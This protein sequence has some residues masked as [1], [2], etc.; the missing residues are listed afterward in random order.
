MLRYFICFIGSAM[1]IVPKCS[2]LPWQNYYWNNWQNSATSVQHSFFLF[3][4]SHGYLTAV[5]RRRQFNP[6]WPQGLVSRV[7]ESTVSGGRWFESHSGKFFGGYFSNVFNLLM[8][9]NR[10]TRHIILSTVVLL[11]ALSCCIYG[12]MFN[13]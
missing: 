3:L 6:R 13:A 12:E 8:R 7:P 1:K 10:L 9:L 4:A 11:T 2:M 5:W